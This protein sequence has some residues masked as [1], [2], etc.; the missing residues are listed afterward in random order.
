MIFNTD[1][2][3]LE[4]L[5]ISGKR[6]KESIYSL[7]NRTYTLG[8]AE[9][10]EQ[11][12]QYP[13]SGRA[14]IKDRSETIQ[15]FCNL[16]L[17]F[18]LE[19]AW[20]EVI[21]A[22]LSD[23][24]SRTQLRADGDT[25]ERKLNKWLGADTQLKATQKALKAIGDCLTHLS[26]FL[27]QLPDTGSPTSFR[28]LQTQVKGMLEEDDFTSVYIA[29][30]TGRLSYEQMATYDRFFR[31]AHYEQMQRILDYIY[32]LDLYIAIATVARERK[33][34]FAEMVS[35]STAQLKLEGF[36]HPLLPNAVGNDLTMSA[37]QRVLF[38]TG[39][40]MAGK[41]T[42]MKSLGITVFLAHIG[43][44]I[45]ARSMRFTLNDGL[46]T[47]INLS[48][49]LQMG[50]SHFYAEVVRVKKLSLELAAGKRLFIIFDELFRGTNVKDAYEATVA[51]TSL[52]AQ[53]ENSLLVVSTHIVEAADNLQENCQ[54]I[55][56]AYMPTMMQGNQ[57]VYP[58]TLT[59]G[60]TE[61]RHGM[62]I[63]QNEGILEILANG[64]KATN[65]E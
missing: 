1:K 47:T 31:F 23:R 58:Y 59:K 48:D 28:E 52:Y 54:N 9:K 33:F 25:L 53:L 63:I 57:P 16:E 26:G 37:S 65:Y 7:F 20:V 41:S 21:V 13:T 27:S 14:E 5:N 42:F 11:I 22:Y 51:I 46:Y 30:A 60:V 6:G 3:T 8:G 55:Q 34:A 32:W 44:P 43:L 38:L 40:N 24:D 4:D 2:Q 12:F 49:S 35:D 64:K 61:D 62:L 39:A 10:L 18:P 29:L 19:A 50:H 45:P 17:G 56:Y 36:Y 15:F